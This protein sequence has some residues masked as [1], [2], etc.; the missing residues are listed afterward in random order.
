MNF[1]SLL[2]FLKNIKDK[3]ICFSST[4]IPTSRSAP[5]QNRVF[6]NKQ[7]PV[8]LQSFQL[9]WQHRRGRLGEL[10]FCSTE[11]DFHR[12]VS[13]QWDQALLPTDMSSAF[14]GLER[15]NC[16]KGDATLPCQRWGVARE[17]SKQG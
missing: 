5:L 9:A 4:P 1:C 3:F 17:E 14:S 16:A 12:A 10:Q 13:A 6:V 15:R 11:G 7:P 2:Y 8:L